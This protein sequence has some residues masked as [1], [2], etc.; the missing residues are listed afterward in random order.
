MRAFLHIGIGLFI[1]AQSAAA[2]AVEQDL[3]N[4][5]TYKNMGI[6][7]AGLGL[8]G[9]AHTWDEDLKGELEGAPLLKQALNLTDIYG[10]SSISLPAL[11]ALW[12]AG[13]MTGRPHLAET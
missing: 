9:L 3:K 4:I 1:G 7:T 8:T 5:F 2:G 10:E 11:L 6:A 13:E 12:G